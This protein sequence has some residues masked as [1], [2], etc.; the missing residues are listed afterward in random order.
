M[1]VATKI[2]QTTIRRLRPADLEAVIALDAKVT[3]RRR[4]E[5][6]KL[7]LK[8]ALAET[9]IEV[10]LAAETDGCFAGFLLAKVYYGEFGQPEMTA[11]LDTVGVHPDFRHLGVGHALMR[12]LYANLAALGIRRLQTEVSW[13]EMGL[14]AFFK[15]EGF[16]P[17]PRLCL[18]RVIDPTTLET[19]RG[20]ELA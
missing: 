20:A 2:G 18:D 7:K 8:S 13:D 9:G 12:Q 17:A 5:F 11:V 10:S 6:F 19:V 3:G 4:D 15:H 16:L 14:L 1:P